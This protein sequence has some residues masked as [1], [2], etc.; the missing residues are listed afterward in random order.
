MNSGCRARCTGLWKGAAVAF[1]TLL[2]SPMLLFA[3]APDAH[4][5]MA[6]VFRQ[7][8][9][10]DVFMSASFEVFDR[11]GHSTTKSFSYRRIGSAGDS[12]TLLAFTDPPELRGVALLSINRPGLNERQFIYVP[13]TQRVRSVAP[14][15]LGGTVSWRVAVVIA[16]AREGLVDPLAVA[17]V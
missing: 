2:L 9:S 7:D 8:T 3:A 4:E 6:A 17:P 15:Q 16:H 11:G 10:H 12:R 13:V 5:I 14:Q 1:G